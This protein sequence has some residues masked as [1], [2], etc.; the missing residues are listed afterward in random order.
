MI[1]NLHMKFQWSVDT[2]Q[3]CQKILSLQVIQVHLNKFE[4]H[5]K[6]HLFQ[7]LNSN[8]ETRVLNKLNAHRMK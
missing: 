1:L 7:Y 4:C 8:C 2:N 6:V 3:G 5:G